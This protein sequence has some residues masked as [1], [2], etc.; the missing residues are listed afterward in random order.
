M[1]KKEAVKKEAVKKVTAA[2]VIKEGIEKA[3]TVDKILKQVHAKVDNS[4]ADESHVKYYAGQMFRDG[5]ITEEEKA[6]YVKGRGRP[7]ET[8][9]KKVDKKAAKPKLK[10]SAK[11]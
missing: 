5:D 4:K 7:A 6:K 10:K 1:A 2:A 11:K 8:A 3:W 9:P